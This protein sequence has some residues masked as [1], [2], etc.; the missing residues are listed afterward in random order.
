MYTVIIP[1]SVKRDIKKLDK[2]VINKVLDLLKTLAENPHR[3][4]LLSGAF[5]DLFKLE[6]RQQGINYRIA[7]SI[8]QNRVEVYVFHVGSRENFYNELRRRI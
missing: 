1:N 4:T 8:N 3:G 2:P 7:Y 6:L 5:S